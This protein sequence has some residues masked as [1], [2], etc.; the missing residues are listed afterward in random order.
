MIK[1]RLGLLFTIFLFAVAG[2]AVVSALDWRQEVAMFPLFVGSMALLLTG[3]EAIRETLTMLRQGKSPGSG[4][5]AVEEVDQ[6]PSKVWAAPLWFFGFVI[7]V[8]LLG[9]PVGLPLMLLFLMRFSFGESWLISV[10]TVIVMEGI[11][12]FLF[13][14]LFGVIWPRPLLL[15]W[16][17]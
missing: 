8:L 3:T 15:E 6:T 12:L 2:W 16:F 11:A 17:V 14:W 7:A 4:E 9:I 10:I 1:E 5:S 13:G